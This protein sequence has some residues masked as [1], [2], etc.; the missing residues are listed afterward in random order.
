MEQSIYKVVK[1]LKASI[2]NKYEL[3]E[4]RVFGSSTRGDRRADSDID[5][6]VHLSQ[7]N[8]Q[9][10]EEL[11]DIAYD[12]ELKHDCLIDLIVFSDEAVKKKY[13]GAPIYQKILDEGAVI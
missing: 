9:I 12:L 7:V 1:E 13:A 11:F 10:E 3:R 6:F 5:V 8:R 2:S 4:I